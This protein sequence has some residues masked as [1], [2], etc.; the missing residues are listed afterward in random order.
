M[1]AFAARPIL[2]WC[3]PVALLLL[4]GIGVELLLQQYSLRQQQVAQQRLQAQANEVSAVLLGEVNVVV[5]FS[6]TPR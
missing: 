5:K 1:K 2:N 6:R 3:T 4:L